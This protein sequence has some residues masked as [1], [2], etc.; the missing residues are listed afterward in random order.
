MRSAIG[1]S[2]DFRGNCAKYGLK[3]EHNL[4]TKALEYYRRK[5]VAEY[6]AP[7]YIA[8]VS[9]AVGHGLFACRDLNP[10]EMVGEYTGALT[11]DW[12][13]EVKEASD[14]KPYLLRFPFDCPYAIDSEKEGNEMRFINHSSK[15]HNVDRLYLFH[16][17][18]L[19]V[20]FIVRTTISKHRQILLDYG[21]NYW[22]ASSPMEIEL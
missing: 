3:A 11:R 6:I 17:G 2:I 12:A 20:I 10:G 16:S 13:A 8:K 5:I 18:L 22:R 15:N 21:K 14:F 19:H 9:D 1:L 4:D 7:S